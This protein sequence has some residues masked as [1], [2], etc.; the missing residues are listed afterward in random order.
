MSNNASY[1]PP[2]MPPGWIALWDEQSQRYYYVE[3]ATGKTQ[4]EVPTSSNL[5]SPM[6]FPTPTN[7]PQSTT[8]NFSPSPASVNFPQQSTPVSG[9]GGAGESNSYLAN[10]TNNNNNN[11]SYPTY[12]SN[13]PGSAMPEGN[14]AEANDRG[15]GSALLSGFMKPN[16]GSSSHHGNS[17]GGFPTNVLGGALGGAVL[18]MAASK[19]SSGKHNN[20]TGYGGHSS[21]GSS[22]GASGLIGSLLGGHGSSSNHQNVNEIE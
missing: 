20:H 3:Q 22:H 17:S 6:G 4:W 12:S 7:T 8:S 14:G 19:L 2:Q 15:L 16:H 18:T 1:P 9:A 11:A 10:T 5:P 13:T 21:H